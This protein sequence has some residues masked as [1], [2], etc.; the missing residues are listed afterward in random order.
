MKHA[1]LT[2]IMPFVLT[3]GA[4]SLFTAENAKTAMD[5]IQSPAGKVITKVIRDRFGRDVDEATAVCWELPE[6]FTSGDEDMDEAES[7]AFVM[8]WAQ[9][10]E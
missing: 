5:V 7:G 9:A 1:A 3:L 8:C 2:L 10:K 4:C 6:G